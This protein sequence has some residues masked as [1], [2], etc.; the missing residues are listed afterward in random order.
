MW[1]VAFH[2]KLVLPWFISNQADDGLCALRKRKVKNV[3]FPLNKTYVDQRGRKYRDEHGEKI[4][5][6]APSPAVFSISP[7]SCASLGSAS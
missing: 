1:R 7:V 2:D 6:Q 5:S 4:K 3:R